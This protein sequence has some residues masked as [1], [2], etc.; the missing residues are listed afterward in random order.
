MKKS[1]TEQ[2]THR[3]KCWLSQRPSDRQMLERE[4]HVA[5]TQDAADIA[6]RTGASL[7]ELYHATATLYFVDESDDDGFDVA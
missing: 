5:T 3:T 6:Q 7:V 1:P 2:A 4:T